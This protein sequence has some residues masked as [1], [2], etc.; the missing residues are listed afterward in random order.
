M[1]VRIQQPPEPRV[2]TDQ[3]L[4]SGVL[5]EGLARGEAVWLRIQGTSMLPWL[6]EGQKIRLLP[7][8]GRRI[9]RGDIVL[10]WRAPGR[11]ILHRVMRI[12]PATGPGAAVLECLGDAESGAP[13]QIPA[14]AVLGLADLSPAR[15]AWYLAVNPLRRWIN[16]R[17]RKYGVRWRHG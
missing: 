5:A 11:P 12:R 13:E 9:A 6:R 7:A 2:V 8:A 16:S 15:R 10:F 14:S 17:C 4:F 1:P 3:N